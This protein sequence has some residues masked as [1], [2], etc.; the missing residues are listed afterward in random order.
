[1]KPENTNTPYSDLFREIGMKLKFS[2]DRRLADIELNGQQGRMIGYI[3][4]NQDRGVIQKDLATQFNR[5]GASIT[6]M[7][8]GLEKKGY[9]KRVVPENN[10][11]QKNIYVLEKGVAL[12]EEFQDVFAEIEGNITKGLTKTEAEQLKALL[13]KVS[14]NL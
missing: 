5:K 13:T 6:S 3:Y 7:L 12:I 8:Q 2:A 4:E 9:I 14:H 11:R 1:M 10:E